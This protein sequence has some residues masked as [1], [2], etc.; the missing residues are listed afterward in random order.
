LASVTVFPSI[1]Y[2]LSLLSIFCTVVSAALLF[3]LF[4]RIGLS[5]FAAFMGVLVTFT[6]PGIWRIA[7]TV[8][9]FRLSIFCS[10]AS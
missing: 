3:V 2:Q 1:V 10:V 9:P 7:T 8:E 5:V 4:S 6:A